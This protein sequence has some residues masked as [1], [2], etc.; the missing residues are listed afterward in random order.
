ML[1]NHGK[2]D[3]ETDRLRD[4]CILAGIAHAIMVA[5][6]PSIANEHSWDGLNYSVQDSAGT[7]GTVTF[8]DDLCV[9]A[10]RND[11]SDRARAEN[12]KY[13]VEYLWNAPPDIIELAEKETFMY[14]LD[15]LDGGLQPFI[16]TAFWGNEKGLKI[17]DTFDDFIEYGGRLLDRQALDYELSIA[18]WANYYNMSEQ[19]VDLLKSVYRRRIEA[20]SDTI[21]LSK[22]EVAAIGY[23]HTMGAEES[24]VSFEELN[25][26]WDE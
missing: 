9:G 12:L 18:A 1:N 10:F 26:Y 8:S 15:Y 24:R 3:W 13:A 16:T 19:Q 21:Y 11:K 22:K 6:Y 4:G 17:N 14:L 23:K 2:L 5:H 25:V 7:R 20:S